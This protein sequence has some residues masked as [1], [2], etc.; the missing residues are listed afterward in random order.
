T[1]VRI[2]LVHQTIKEESNLFIVWAVG[3]YPTI[4]EKDCFFSVGGKIIPGFYAG[5]K[6]LKIL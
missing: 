1:I 6:R 2:K 5:N 3:V 4:F